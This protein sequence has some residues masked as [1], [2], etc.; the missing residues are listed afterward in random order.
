MNGWRIEMSNQAIDNLTE[1]PPA[2]LP[3]ILRAIR[4]LAR[5][6]SDSNIK[7][8]KAKPNTWRLRVG[9]WRILFEFKQSE[10]IITFTSLSDRKDAY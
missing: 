6:P 4:L 1:I 7:K 10:H 9:K 3:A 2:Q 5:N 8:L